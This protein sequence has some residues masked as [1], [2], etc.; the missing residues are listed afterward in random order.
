MRREIRLTGFGG[1]GIILAGYVLGKAA[2]IFDRKHA[3]MVQSYGP[4]ARGSACASQVVMQDTEILYPFLRKQEILIAMSQEGY[5]A[6]KAVLE[7]DGIL[8]YD[9]RLVDPGQLPPAKH[10]AAIP[11]TRIAEELGRSLVANIV[12]LGFLT[13]QTDIVSPEAME[14][15][16][17]SSVPKGTEELNLKAFH[18]GIHY[19]VEPEKEPISLRS[20]PGGAR[21]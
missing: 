5:D 21:S 16:V 4:E 19:G 8:L 18:A 14:Q 3:T 10:T 6:F 2:A 7:P 13:G 12:M 1:Q 15:A 11:A 17:L 9:E 20:S